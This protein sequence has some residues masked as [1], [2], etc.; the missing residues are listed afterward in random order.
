MRTPGFPFLWAGKSDFFYITHI[1]ASLW[2]WLCFAE[3][4]DR[5]DFRAA[6][7]LFSVTRL[8]RESAQG[9]LGEGAPT[10]RLFAPGQVFNWPLRLTLLL[11]DVETNLK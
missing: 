4:L 5:E 8:S 3:V 7:A 2:L 9:T 11:L 10:N 1:L 6:E